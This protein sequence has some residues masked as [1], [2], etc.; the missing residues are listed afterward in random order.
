[1]KIKQ[2]QQDIKNIIKLIS[3]LIG[4]IL[5]VIASLTVIGFCIKFILFII[6]L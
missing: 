4:I 1:M 6:R 3:S 2:L 5:F